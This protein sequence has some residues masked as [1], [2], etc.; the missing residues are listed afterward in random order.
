MIPAKEMDVVIL[1]GGLGKRLQSVFSKGPKPMAS[2]SDRPFLDILI[3]Y[4]SRFGYRRFILCVGHKADTIISYYKKRSTNQTILFSREDKALGTGGAMTLAS[5]LVKSPFFL[6]LNGD[7]LCLIDHKLFLDFHFSRSADMSIVLTRVENAQEFGLMS[8]DKKQRV[9]SFQEKRNSR[10]KAWVNAGIYLLQKNIFQ[11][12]SNGTPFS[13]ENDFFPNVLDK[14]V[15]GYK[16][17]ERLVDIG[18]P[19]RY[20]EAQRYFSDINSPL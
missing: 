13:L 7:S 10:G 18:T 20:K 19:E 16:T 4:I 1:C 3:D 2:V 12:F 8:L 9:T 15:F 11:G 5:S 6:G 14:R 17:N